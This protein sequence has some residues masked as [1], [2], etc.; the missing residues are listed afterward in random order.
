MISSPAQG[1]L[2]FDLTT[3][4]FWFRN[5]SSWVQLVDSVSTEVHRSAPN[6]IYTGMTDYV[7]VGTSTPAHKLEVKTA[8]E[9]YG[10]SHTNG[11]VDVAT[12]VSNGTGGWIGTKSNHPF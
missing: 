2:V 5:A 4:S 8:N 6:M 3:N 10:I 1:L 12:Y 7:G 9:Q 11:T